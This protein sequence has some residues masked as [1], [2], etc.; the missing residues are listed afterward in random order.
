[1]L[2]PM[3]WSKKLL[4]YLATPYTV[5]KETYL[6]LNLKPDNNAICNGKKFNGKK[7]GAFRYLNFKA[8]KDASK[9]HGSTINDFLTSLITVSLHDYLHRVKDDLEYKGIP[10]PEDYQI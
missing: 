8:L 5:L 10:I 9:K 4:I 7:K 6:L 3:H 2:K 1:M